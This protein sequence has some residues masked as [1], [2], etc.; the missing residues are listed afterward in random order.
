MYN[1]ENSVIS[2]TLN[3]IMTL[4]LTH[5]LSTYN[6]VSSYYA[7]RLI[8]SLTQEYLLLRWVNKIKI[9]E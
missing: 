4:L 8:F 1:S 7:V 3:R 9:E 5:Y 6:I 2:S